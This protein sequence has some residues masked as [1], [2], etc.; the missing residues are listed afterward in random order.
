MCPNAALELVGGV[1]VGGELRIENR[2]GHKIAELDYDPAPL[3]GL[4]AIFT[5]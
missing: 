4:R 1:S 2:D 3:V 5:F